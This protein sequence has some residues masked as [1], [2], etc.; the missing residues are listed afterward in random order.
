MQE[1]PVSS[2]TPLFLRFFA[3]CFLYPYEE[4]GYEL[5]YLF[6]ELERGTLVE[7]E[8]PHLDQILNIINQ[9]QG[10]D[11]KLLRE[12]YVSLFTQWEGHQP[13]C[14]LLAST[15]MRG[16]GRSYNPDPFTNDLLESGIPVDEEGD[17]DSIVNYLEYLSLI[18]EG[19]LELLSAAD[20]TDFQ[21]THIY[22]WIP[23][24]CDVLYQVS[25]ISFYKEVASG[26]KNYLLQLKSYV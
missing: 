10:E 16:L 11:I 7:E 17:L 18:A 5:Q 13:D 26:L 19:D 1:W 24:F 21:N 12:N 3:R 20:I 14:P 23:L 22:S 4:M 2:Q 15:F 6:R 9:Y 8:F 25:Q